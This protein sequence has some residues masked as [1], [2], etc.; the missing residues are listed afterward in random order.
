[1]LD[2]LIKVSGT[3]Q[4]TKGDKPFTFLFE[5]IRHRTEGAQVYLNVQL[6]NS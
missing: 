6:Q 2:N 1:V 5:E 3:A 4:I